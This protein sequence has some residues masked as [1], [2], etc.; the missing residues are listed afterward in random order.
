[1]KSYHIAVAVITI[2]SAAVVCIHAKDETKTK[3]GKVF[4]L[5]SIVSFKNQGCR[6]QSGTTGF[7]ASNRNG[8]CYT[9]TECSSKGGQASGNCAAGFGVCCLFISTAAATISENCSYIQNPSFPSAYTA[10]SSLT[11]TVSKCSNDVCSIRLD[12]ETFVIAGPTST[13]DATGCVDTFTVTAS[14]SGY[15]T[16]VICGSNAGQHLYVDIGPASGA[17]ASLA[18]TFGTSTTV[19]RTWE[20]K[21]TQIECSNPS[22][23]SD[24][25]C[26]QYHTGTTGRVASFN[27]AQTT[28]TIMQHLPSQNYGICI[29]QEAGFCCVQYTLCGDSNSW[30][31]DGVA[32]AGGETGSECTTDYL[33]ISGLSVGQ[34]DT[35][36]LTGRLCGTAFN[37]VDGNAI[38]A[39]YV[40]DCNAPFN[41]QFVTD[42]AAIAPAAAIG[43][44]QRG[45]CL[46]Y[47]Q[48]GC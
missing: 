44:T 12:F 45:F 11:W 2:F 16:P 42:A 48:I 25:G 22:R 20:L 40:C 31:I 46:Q 38:A 1:M 29:R 47:Q 34:C 4:S 6:S 32:P 14:P 36:I 15:V 33:A 24:A 9:S 19:S 5:F 37:S 27:F 26:L 39:S 18:F 21:V 17:T 3:E 13:T 10:T 8:T 35:N 28:T 43:P 41:I 30:T 7:T 23:P